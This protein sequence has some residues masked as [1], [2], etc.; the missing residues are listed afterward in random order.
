[1]NTHTEINYLLNGV[2]FTNIKI[3]PYNILWKNI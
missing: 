1:M 3:S 2:K